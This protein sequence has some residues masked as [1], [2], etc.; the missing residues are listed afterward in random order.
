MMRGGGGPAIC[1]WGG[2][3]RKRWHNDD[4][5][6]VRRWRAG[7]GAQP[8][9]TAQPSLSTTPCGTL[10]LAAGVLE[11]CG[12][13]LRK[14]TS[15]TTPNPPHNT[16]ALNGVKRRR[17]GASNRGTWGKHRITQPVGGRTYGGGR[18]R[19]SARC[20]DILGG[21]TPQRRRRSITR[22]DG[23]PDRPLEGS[24]RS[25]GRLRAHSHTKVAGGGRE[26]EK[27]YIDKKRNVQS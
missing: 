26:T 8:I 2:G 13:L 1:G 11:E 18:R 21:N 25:V 10:P 16:D 24:D 15:T 14:G 9:E 17:A 12:P 27:G 19:A 7:L 5:V 23:T 20:A 6:E 22:R 3:W 4:G